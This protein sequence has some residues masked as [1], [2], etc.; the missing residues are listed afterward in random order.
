VPHSVNL[1]APSFQ[2]GR[3]FLLPMSRKEPRACRGFLGGRMKRLERPER[4]LDSPMLFPTHKSDKARMRKRPRPAAVTAN[5]FLWTEVTG[6]APADGISISVKCHRPTRPVT[7]GASDRRPSPIA[8]IG[9]V[10]G[11]RSVSRAVRI[12]YGTAHDSACHHTSSDT[13]TD[14]TTPTARFGRL[15]CQQ[16]NC[17]RCSSGK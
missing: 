11:L 5:K 6:S 2:A 10:A 13:D 14:S 3:G 16:G 1:K 4:S 7:T 15:G 8:G 12:G 9:Y 17:K